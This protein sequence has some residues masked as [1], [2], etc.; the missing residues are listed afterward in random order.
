[1]A[2]RSRPAVD[3]PRA[4]TTIPAR[5]VWAAAA[6]VVFA[7]AWLWAP[8]LPAGDPP[9]GMTHYAGLIMGNQPWGNLWFMAVPFVLVYSVVLSGHAIT[10]ARNR[11]TAGGLEPV[12]VFRTGATMRR[13]R[14][15]QRAAGIVAGLYF[16]GLVGYLVPRAVWPLIS[17]GGFFGWADIIAVFAYGLAGL[18]GAVLYAQETQLLPARGV[19][20]LDENDRL[21]SQDR[22]I[23][24]AHVA[25]I[26][27]MFAPWVLGY[28]T[29]MAGM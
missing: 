7:V 23:V 19:E 14:G 22:I 25:M 13:L 20:L 8:D 26:F 12:E 4:T 29:R 16:V 5:L 6:A 9:A 18:A 2:I 3:H 17:L 21:L 15:F 24:A 11:H 10:R 28:G 1:M 27:G